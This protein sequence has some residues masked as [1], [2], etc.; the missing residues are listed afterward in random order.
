MKLG[1]A[2]YQTPT[3]YSSS[4]NFGPEIDDTKTVEEIINIGKKLEIVG[5]VVYEESPLVEAKNLK[6]NITKAKEKL[7]F[8]PIWNT[9]KAIEATFEW[10]NSYYQHTS[11]AK[12]LIDK[13]LLNYLNQE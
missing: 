11:T 12:D 5:E 4:W 10:Y 8:K 2:L 3:R 1:I 9:S 13:D 6:L 7:N